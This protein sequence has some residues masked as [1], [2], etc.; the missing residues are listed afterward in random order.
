MKTI[1]QL[2]RY[3]IEAHLGAGAYADVYRALDSTL[4]RTV[5]LKVLKP[6]LMADL[7]AFGR[8]VQEAQVAAN[9][10]HPQIATVLDMGEADG[11]Y[12]L[13][14]RY[15]DGQ[16]LD[17]VLAE[18][19]AMRWSQALKI[20]EQVG[21]ALE[22]AH[23][24]EL[25][26]R[27]VKPQNIIIS[28]EEGAVLTDFGLVRALASSGMTTTGTMLGT[29]HYMAPEIWEG[30]QAGP[31]ADQYALACIL[32]EMLTGKV[33]FDGRTPPAVMGKHFKPPGLPVSW[34]EGVPAGIDV[35]LRKAL[36]KNPTERYANLEDF[37]AALENLQRMMAATVLKPKSEP[38][39]K[40]VEVK[41]ADTTPSTK[42]AQAIKESQRQAIQ[43]NA[44]LPSQPKIR[45]W[46]W[47]LGGLFALGVMMLLAIGITKLWSG[48]APT[49]AYFEEGQV[50]IN[51]SKGVAMRLVPAGEFAMGSNNGN[52]DEKPVHQIYLDAYYMDKYEVTNGLYK[53]CVNAGE[54]DSPSD[55]KSYARASYYG[56]SEFENYPVI[57]VDW[58]Q[59]KTYCEWRGAR[60]PTEA[61]WEKAARGTDR[62]TYPWG[63]DS[64]NSNLLN[65]NDVASDTTEVGK[66]PK[67]VSLY[68]LYDMAGNV[69]EWVNDWYGE[70]YYQSSPSSNPF[71]P[72]P[73]E[74]RALRGG[75]WRDGDFIVRTSYRDW[76][77]P[78][79]TRS[80]LG[81]RCSRGTPP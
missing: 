42:P 75:S 55:T 73:G 63:N 29:P 61:E 3:Q 51:D 65:Y 43:E 1:T 16:S 72:G 57:F 25:V 23:K 71:G 2:G 33:L 39:E 7:N 45:A 12:Y 66:Y 5:A 27:D 37:S 77:N 54:C 46:I 11:H 18:G 50:E 79:S 59:A 20:F 38:P 58:N 56:N 9:L 48:A 36:A 17:R 8:F 53:I 32:V 80:I 6:A 68:G 74:N 44:P 34:A 64:P 10:F 60:L 13:A 15:V 24:K 28:D 81:F 22:F 31:A 30:E 76:S 52:A 67:G 69:W 62:R 47:A 41:R 4:K 78:A 19:G 26:H 70:T 21:D 35:I 14:M 40:L 49:S